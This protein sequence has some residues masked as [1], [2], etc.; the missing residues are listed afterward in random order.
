MENIETT[1]NWNYIYILATSYDDYDDE[2][3]HV[4]LITADLITALDK[5]INGNSDHNGDN[6]RLIIIKNDDCYT[7]LHFNY[8]FYNFYRKRKVIVDCIEFFAKS[9][10][11]ESIKI[12]AIN[13]L[14]NIL[15]TTDFDKLAEEKKQ[16]ALK[17]RDN[18]DRSRLQQ[19]L[20]QYK[21]EINDGSI[22]IK[23]I[24]E[25]DD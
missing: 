24:L 21:S 22:D 12:D 10:L 8:D 5:M 23:S 3:Y 14:N 20:L 19:L 1:F 11:P 9:D 17:D 15:E 4:N 16:E 25:S 13:Y 6:D 7:Q 2:Y 18:H